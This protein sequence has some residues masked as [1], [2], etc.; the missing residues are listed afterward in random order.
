MSEQQNVPWMHGGK[1]VTA[2]MVPE[3][4]VG[5][6]YLIEHWIH[7]RVVTYIGK[8]ALNSTRKV[9]IGKRAIA[10]EKASRADGKAKTVKMVTKPMDWQN[11]WG[12]SKTLHAARETGEGIW[13]RTIV[14]W[15]YSKKNM[16]YAETKWQMAL[17]VMDKPSYNDH[18]GNWYHQDV[19]MGYWLQWKE[20][21]KN[22][23]RK[24]RK[25]K[26]VK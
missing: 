16:S 13:K 8:K 6:V 14:Q 12:S 4:A 3:W 22:R 9:R 17:D 18:I 24:P 1:V 19:S 20:E 10:A 23:P 26:E 21:M 2:D 25:K 7:G 11:Y 15:C 5:Y